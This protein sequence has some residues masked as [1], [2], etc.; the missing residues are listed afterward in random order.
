MKLDLPLDGSTLM[1][2]WERL[3][4]LPAGKTAFS[5]AI[6]Q[7]APYTGTLG[8]RVE[9][10]E[11]GHARVVV[12]DRRGIRNHLKSIH[13]IALA[14]LA[15]M[16]SGLAVVSGLPKGSRGILTELSVEY[17]KKARGTLAADCRVDPLGAVTADREVLAIAEIKDASGTLVARGRARWRIG[18]NRA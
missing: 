3:A 15:E 16:S 13:A 14:N 1:S 6:G 10:L 2:V 4:H 9:A 11:P 8:G 12:E 18:P 5:L 17:L 7:L